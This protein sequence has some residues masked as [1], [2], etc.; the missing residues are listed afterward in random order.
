MSATHLKSRSI[1]RMRAD[2]P[3]E[4]LTR[5]QPAEQLAPGQG[6]GG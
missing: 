3:G 2:D 1:I 4:G 6:R 5:F